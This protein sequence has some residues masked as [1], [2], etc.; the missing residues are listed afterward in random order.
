[1]E[2]IGDEV[3]SVVSGLGPARTMPDVIAAWPGA[4]G[5]QIARNA[6]PAR[7]GRDGTLHVAVSSSTWAFELAQLAEEIAERL[8]QALGE[9]APW[10]LR[11]APGPL[12]EAPVRGE[13]SVKKERRKPSGAERE[14]AERLVSGIG[15]AD[16][17]TLVAKAAAESL[18]KAADDRPVC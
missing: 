10:R 12:P 17:R 11:F 9:S 16:L 15:D 8:Q 18:A 13:K 14:R 5:K 1:M 4:V 7:I 2:R 3:R 6:W